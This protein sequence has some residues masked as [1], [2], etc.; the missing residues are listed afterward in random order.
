MKRE[1]AW[2]VFAGEYNDSTVE[3]KSEKE[4]MPSY[5]VTPLGAKINRVFIIGVLTDVENVSEGGEFVRAHISD[6][7]GVFTLYSGSYQKEATDALSEIEVPAFVAVIGKIRTYLPEE[8]TLYVSIR[9]EKII[10]VDSKTRDM[11]ILETCKNTKQRIEATLE[12]MKM[13]DSN[14]F[15]LRKLGYSKDLS[16]GIVKALKNYGKIDLNKYVA[17]IQES[18]EYLVPGQESSSDSKKEKIVKKEED[19]TKE[20]KEE[21]KELSE[22]KKEFEEIEKNVLE[23]IKKIEGEDGASWDNI[24]EE[25]KKNKLDKDSVEEALTSLM[26]K[27]LIYEPI[28]GTI[29]TT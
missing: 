17:L 18:L 21:E 1:T 15:E 9:P 22:N 23:I 8:G 13:E 12:A 2:R 20:K 4:M 10:E 5:I 16:E 11:W 3:I 24:T 7:T 28:L 25:C 19:K 26:D 6:P 29:K 14:E 27:G